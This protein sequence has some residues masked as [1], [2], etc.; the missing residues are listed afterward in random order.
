RYRA[1]GSLQ[2]QSD[3]VGPMPGRYRRAAPGQL[4]RSESVAALPVRQFK[5]TTV[6]MFLSPRLMSRCA[7]CPSVTE[8]Q[9]R[10]FRLSES[11]RAIPAMLI[12]HQNKTTVMTSIMHAVVALL[13]VA[14]SARAALPVLSPGNAEVED[15]PPPSEKVEQQGQVMPECAALATRSMCPSD[16]SERED[17]RKRCC[18]NPNYEYHCQEQGSGGGGTESE[19]VSACVTDHKCPTDG[20]CTPVNMLVQSPTPK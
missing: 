3:E 4:R 5:V 19:A 2:S 9:K 18:R 1:T 7:T 20:Q 17:Q 13:F 6:L 11:S 16:Q 14:C 15:A 10:G 12:K 8:S